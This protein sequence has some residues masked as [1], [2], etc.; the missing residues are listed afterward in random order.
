MDRLVQIM[1]KVNWTAGMAGM[2]IEKAQKH[3]CVWVAAWINS[4]RTW[5]VNGWVKL[6]KDPERRKRVR[7][8]EN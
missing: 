6:P 1:E 2:N 4:Y 8:L 3:W 5:V 7:S